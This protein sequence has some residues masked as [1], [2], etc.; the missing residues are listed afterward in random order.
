MISNQFPDYPP[1]KCIEWEEDD[2][3]ERGPGV[4]VIYIVQRNPFCSLSG[5]GCALREGRMLG[6]WQ[7]LLEKNQ[8]KWT[9]ELRWFF[10]AG[11]SLRVM[12]FDKKTQQSKWQIQQLLSIATGGKNHWEFFS[13]WTPTSSM[14]TT[15][16]F[17]MSEVSLTFAH[18][19]QS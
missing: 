15:F 8:T 13:T 16:S 5:K 6:P 9:K 2:R 18:A 3:P 11:S 10:W 12:I 1:T 14:V 4:F 17:L 19:S 7:K